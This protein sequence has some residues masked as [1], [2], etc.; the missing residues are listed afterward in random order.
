MAGNSLIEAIEN[1]NGLTMLESET[2]HK[3]LKQFVLLEKHINHKASTAVAKSFLKCAMETRKTLTNVKMSKKGYKRN[4]KFL[5]F[6]VSPAD[7]SPIR[8]YAWPVISTFS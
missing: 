2:T 3:I 8:E 7:V 5:L 6:Q 1:L 4:I